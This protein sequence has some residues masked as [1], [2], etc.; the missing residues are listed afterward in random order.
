MKSFRDYFRL[1]E[2]ALVPVEGEE[3][4]INPSDNDEGKVLFKLIHLAWK[5]HNATTKAFF[6]KL[7]QVNPEIASE[8]GHL[9]NDSAEPPT[10]E[11]PEHQ[12]DKDVVRPTLA[13]TGSGDMDA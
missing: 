12:K 9:N 11:R 1:R 2:N 13:D 5:N 8:L 7:A 4:S 6:R 10:N 3:E